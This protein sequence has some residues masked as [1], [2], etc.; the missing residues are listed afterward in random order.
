[1]AGRFI[2]KDLFSNHITWYNKAMSALFRLD[3]LE[4]ERLL[5]KWHIA[6]SGNK[7]IKVELEVIDF[8]K[9]PETSQALSKEPEKALALWDERWSNNFIIK[10]T[11]RH[12]FWTELEKAYF[13]RITACILEQEN[14]DE[15]CISEEILLC[16]LKG[17][18]FDHVIQK[19]NKLLK[20]SCKRGR[21]LGY[22]ADAM[23]EKGEKDKALEFYLA[24]LL[25]GSD[26]VDFR[27]I[28]EKRVKKLLTDPAQ[29]IEN[30]YNKDIVFYDHIKSW[31]AA[32][33]LLTGILP[34]PH[35][36]DSKELVGMYRGLNRPK[37]LKNF[38]ERPGIRFAKALILSE[39]GLERLSALGIDIVKIRIIMKEI[40][41]ELFAIYMAEKD[42]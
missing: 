42:Q 23:M 34:I 12:S 14:K 31:A 6:C 1:M 21:V 2:Q 37:D 39:Q 29:V 10:Q 36:L 33:G 11:P 26:E 15:L 35:L 38:C 8:L 7:N 4:A 40:H 25:E 9:D 22:L 27:T 19:G 5:K 13:S 3:V 32:T 28:K 30:R 24:A 18:A 41:Q 20:V 16:L 17:R